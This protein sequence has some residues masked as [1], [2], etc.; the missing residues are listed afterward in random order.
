MNVEKFTHVDH[1]QLQDAL[2]VHSGAICLQ[3]KKNNSPFIGLMRCYKNSVLNTDETADG[4]LT[5]MT[6]GIGREYA[7][8]SIFKRF[9]A[10]STIGDVRDY[11]I[12]HFGIGSAGSTVD[13][14]DVVTLQ[15]PDLCDTGLYDPIEINSNA[16]PIAPDDRVAKEIESTGPG[17]I[18]G[19]I[20]Q[21][22]STSQ[23]FQN[24]TGLYTVTKCTCVIDN[25]E[26]T[27]LQPAQT[28]KIDEACLYFTKEDPVGTFT[29]P[30][31]FAHICFAPKFIEKES[32]FIIE[33][34]II[35]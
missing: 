4:W 23:E 7:A 8:Q 31:S 16:I 10:N 28:V 29:D 26:P 24:C 20:M 13:Q 34:Y 27:Y 21:D 1:I 18:A 3:Q 33:W 17:G 6:I 5:N 30:K 25:Q 35:A 22:T 19:A 32:I 15:G 9:H 12:D 2:K 11:K 14:N